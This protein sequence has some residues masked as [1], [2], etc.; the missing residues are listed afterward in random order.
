MSVRSPTSM[1]VQLIPQH[2]I[3]NIYTWTLK[4]VLNL[5]G[6]IKKPVAS[7]ITAVVSGETDVY[8]S[9]LGFVG[10]VSSKMEL[11]ASE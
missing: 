8:Q 4:E 7:V 9:R 10:F 3:G 2:F 1:T 5:Q 6:L 11:F